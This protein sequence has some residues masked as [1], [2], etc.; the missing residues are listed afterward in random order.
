MRKNPSLAAASVSNRLAERTVWTAR[1]HT[2]WYT[3]DGLQMTFR[4][5]YCTVKGERSGGYVV[6]AWL[7]EKFEHEGPH[8]TV[9]RS[10]LR[11]GY[12]P[13]AKL[14]MIQRLIDELAKH[15]TLA[16]HR[17]QVYNLAES[18]YLNLD[19]VDKISEAEG[20]TIVYTEMSIADCEFW[21]VE[22]AKF[23]MKEAT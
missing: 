4:G 23:P 21:K 14:R 1:G 7:A 8:R 5:R 16:R 15:R 11:K 19:R 3:H 13:I 12:K 2:S 6:D 18:R 17:E 22:L 10:R 20:R 9:L